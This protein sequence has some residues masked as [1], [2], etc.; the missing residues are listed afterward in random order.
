MPI[1][2]SNNALITTDS[3]AAL[4]YF[5]SFYFGAMA[6]L[7]LAREI[8]HN[9]IFIYIAAAGFFTGLA[10]ASKFSMVIIAPILIGIWGIDFS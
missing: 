2:I 8:S 6:S 3:A 4:F 9:K 1:F 5:I 10:M 7:S